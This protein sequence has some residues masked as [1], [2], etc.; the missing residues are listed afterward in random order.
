LTGKIIR[1][2]CISIQIS[3]SN[4]TRS[5]KRKSEP[6]KEEVDEKLLNKKRKKEEEDKNKDETINDTGKMT[7]KDFRKFLK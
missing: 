5:K 2:R 1:G 6:I 3:K 4:I 7:N